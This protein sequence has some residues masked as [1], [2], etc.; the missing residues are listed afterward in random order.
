MCQDPYTEKLPY[1]TRQ[2][3]I[4]E[5][6]LEEYI[7]PFD[8]REEVLRQLYI[9]TPVPRLKAWRR[10]LHTD[11]CFRVIDFRVIW[12]GE[13]NWLVTPFYEEG[14]GTVIDWVPAAP[15]SRH[16]RPLTP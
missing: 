8:D 15:P 10:D 3:L 6:R 7:I 16:L 1:P 4:G 5:V 11:K 14:G 13:R 12:S 2:L 9:F